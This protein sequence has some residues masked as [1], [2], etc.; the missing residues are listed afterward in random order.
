MGFKA[1][2]CQLRLQCFRHWPTWTSSL[3]V[4]STK[5]IAVTL[6]VHQGEFSGKKQ[7]HSLPWSAV[8]RY[9]IFHF[10]CSCEPSITS[11]AVVAWRWPM[12]QTTETSGFIGKQLPA[13]RL[14]LG[15]LTDWT[16]NSISKVN[17]LLFTLFY[18]LFEAYNLLIFSCRPNLAEQHKVLLID[19]ITFYCLDKY[20]QRYT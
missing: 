9:F 2:F 17:Y 16:I 4:S 8:I 20:A 15:D 18:V 10:F 6:D 5:I 7:Y 3:S 1:G 13:A 14:S 11:M 12:M 19:M